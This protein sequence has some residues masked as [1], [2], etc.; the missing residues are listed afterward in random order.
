MRAGRSSYR[1]PDSQIPRLQIQP[2]LRKNPSMRRHREHDAQRPTRTAAASPPGRVRQR[3]VHAPHAGQHRQRHEQRRD[4]GQDLHHR[5]QPVRHGRQVRVEKAG[6]PVLEEHRLVRE[7]HEVVVTSRK[8]SPSLVD[9]R[10][11]AA[12]EPADRVALRNDPPQRGDVGLDVEH[13]PDQL[14]AR[15]SKTS[16]RAVEPVLSLSTSGR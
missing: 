15:S 7:A 1:I 4:D 8:R 10:E 9:E 14:L 11:L 12:R 16:P 6:D 2:L 13:L 3:D 5:V